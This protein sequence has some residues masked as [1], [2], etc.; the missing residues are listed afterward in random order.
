[1]DNDD[2]GG[3]RGDARCITGHLDLELVCFDLR[4]GLAWAVARREGEGLGRGSSRY[5]NKVDMDMEQR[6]A[7]W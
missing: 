1:M 4:P 7:R 3:Q 2:L 5:T 6:V